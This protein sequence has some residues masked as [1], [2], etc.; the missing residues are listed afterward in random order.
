VGEGG[1]KGGER[2]KARAK[3]SEKGKEM[4]FSLQSPENTGRMTLWIQQSET[5]SGLRTCRALVMFLW[6]RRLTTGRIRANVY[7]ARGSQC[8]GDSFKV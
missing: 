2:K 3:G 5:L 4:G 6:C 1:E 8:S 7:R